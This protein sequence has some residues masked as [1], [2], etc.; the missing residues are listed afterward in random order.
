M[1]AN[2]SVSYGRFVDQH[3]NTWLAVEGSSGCT[4][5]TTPFYI[6]RKNNVFPVQSAPACED[7]VDRT[8]CGSWPV[9]GCGVQPEYYERR[10]VKV[11][12][13]ARLVEQPGKLTLEPM[14]C[15]T[16]EP[17]DGYDQPP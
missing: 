7:T 14:T 8:V 2:E 13:N 10:F 16:F 15:H 3:G 1:W 17:E 4:E 11:P 6:D 12:R 5:F 9:H